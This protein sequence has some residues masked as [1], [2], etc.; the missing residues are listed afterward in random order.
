[1]N[2]E[3]PAYFNHNQGDDGKIYGVGENVII[4]FV[5][6]KLSENIESWV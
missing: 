4:H 1:M 5:I 6:I 3:H 2:V